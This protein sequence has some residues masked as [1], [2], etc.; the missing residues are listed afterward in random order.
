MSDNENKYDKVVISQ[1]SVKF[2]EE[3]NTDDED[4]IIKNKNLYK[5]FI[6]ILLSA[7]CL[8][9]SLGINEMFKLIFVHSKSDQNNINEIKYYIVYIIAL[10]LI[11]LSFAYFLKIEVL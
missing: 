2:L 8:S 10:F 7:F 4:T 11:T 3:S 1:R 6:S 9:I 5:S